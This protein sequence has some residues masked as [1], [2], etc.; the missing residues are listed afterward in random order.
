M[1]SQQEVQQ[2]LQQNLGQEERT[3]QLVE[4]SMPTLLQQAMQAQGVGG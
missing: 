3:A 2:L 4:Q 1:M